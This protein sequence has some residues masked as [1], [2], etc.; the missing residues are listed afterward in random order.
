[1]KLSRRQSLTRLAAAAGISSIAGT[2]RADTP[3]PIRLVVLD[4]GGTIIEDRGDVPEELRKALSHHAVASTPAE[5]AKWRG[6]AKREIIRHFVELQSP[7]PNV[8]RT[9]LI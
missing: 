1:M 7:A 5:I 3:P 2:T 9:K 6:A 8:D 4:V